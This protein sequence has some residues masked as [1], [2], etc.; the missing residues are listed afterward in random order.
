MHFLEKGLLLP[1]IWKWKQA[2]SSSTEWAWPD[3]GPKAT[4]IW[5]E[6]AISGQLCPLHLYLSFLISNGSG[7]NDL[8]G[9]SS[10]KLPVLKLPWLWLTN[11]LLQD[12]T[13]PALLATYSVTGATMA[14]HYYYNS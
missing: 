9:S 7:P 3:C 5:G 4:V 8:Q 14:R 6:A 1:V 13:S 2:L 10:T 12:L 11:H